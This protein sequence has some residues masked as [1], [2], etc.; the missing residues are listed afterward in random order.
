MEVLNTSFA[1]LQEKLLMLYEQESDVLEQQILFWKLI[2]RENVLM[3]YA[4]KQGL[5]RLGMQSLPSLTVSEGKAKQAIMMQTELESLGRSGFAGESWSMQDTSVERYLA[6]PPNTF[7]K[8]PYSVAVYYDNDP[9][10]RHEYINWKRIYFFGADEDWHVVEGKT[11]DTGLYYVTDD[12]SKEYFE[13]FSVDA[14]R[15]S[16]TDTWTVDKPTVSTPSSSVHTA[17]A[18]STSPATPSTKASAR[19]RTRLPQRD[20]GVGVGPVS[21]SE[22]GSLRRTSYRKRGSTRLEQLIADARDPPIVLLKGFTKALKHF[23]KTNRAVL[24]LSGA[25]LSTIFKWLG[26]GDRARML[27]AFSTFTQR[28]EFLAR[29]QLSA[30]TDV[31]LG[32]L[33]SI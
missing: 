19:K 15:F 18:P 22:V 31:A 5:T 26:H 1:A 28:R 10:N 17:S 27:L 13:M 2:R 32:N 23:K 24:S 33:D 8:D 25:R 12:G 16:R 3:F 29:V 6:N 21:A 4:R 14:S 11:D 20:R 7:K 9:T 30:E